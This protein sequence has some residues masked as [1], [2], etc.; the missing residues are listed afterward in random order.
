MTENELQA[1]IYLFQMGKVG[2]VSLQSTLA[3]QV[4]NH[5]VHAH[6]YSEMAPADKYALESR[7]RANLPVSVITPVREPLSRNVSAFFQNF[8]RDTGFEVADRQWDV[9]EVRE[10]FLRRYPHQVC[11]DWFDCQFRPTF[12]IDVYAQV[13]PRQQKWATYQTGSI[14]VL[15]Y[16]CDLGLSEQLAVLSGFL[17][18]KIDR[19]VLANRADD[20][21]YA[22]LYREFTE[23]AGFPEAYI[24]RMC[25]SQYCR[26]FWS[27]QEI[28]A[29][30]E[31]WRTQRVHPQLQAAAGW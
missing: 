23:A 30:A 8:K 2:S 1:P 6:D 29:T 4:N 28:R 3:A 10:L 27:E 14:R 25:G 22:G 16:R 26:H 19:W 15:V 20:K 21:D 18:R 7:R 17:G 13:F 9:D 11:L 24:S 12:G 5:I 31:K